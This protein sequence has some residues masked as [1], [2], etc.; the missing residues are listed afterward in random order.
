M[1]VA[2]VC[3]A[4]LGLLLIALGFAVSMARAARTS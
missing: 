3:I 1:T 4:L 2:L